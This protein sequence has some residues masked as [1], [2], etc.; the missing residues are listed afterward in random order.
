MTKLYYTIFNL[1]A[2]TAIIFVVVDSSYRIIRKQVGQEVTNEISIKAN[3]DIKSYRKPP[4]R[5]Y[6]VI[7]KKNIFSKIEKLPEKEEI[8]EIDTLEPTTLKITL[9]GTAPTSDPNTSAA[10][11]EDKSKRSEDMYKIGDSI[12][13]AIIKKILRGKIVLKVGDREEILM[14]DEPTS[15]ESSDVRSITP[16]RTPERRVPS[17]TITVRR[18]DIDRSLT[19]INELLSE[20]SIRPHFKDGEPD[21][22]AITGVKANSIFRKMGFRNGD[23]VKG[24][25]GNEIKTPEDLIGLYNDL[26]SETEVSLEIIRRGRERIHNIRIR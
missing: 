10:F 11:I 7:S 2:L 23:I 1:I 5:N 18:N 21:G 25:G 3:S 16:R 8:P 19:D 9:R 4:L 14:M 26:K 22:L 6:D 24:I 12:Q 20:A 15:G 13:N 17:R